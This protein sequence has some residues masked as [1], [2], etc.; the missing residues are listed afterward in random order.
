[1]NY[2]EKY[3]HWLE[4]DII[5]E[6]TKNELRNIKDDKEIEDRFYK[7]LEFG[8][9]GLRGII[10]AGTNRMNIYTVSKAT[11]GFANYL[12][13]AFENPSVAIAYDS[14]NMSKEF[15]KATALTLAANNIKVYLYEGL[16]P[17]PVLS[18]TVRHLNCTGGVV[19]TA[20][21]NPKE[22]NGY[23]V[24]DEFGGQVTDLKAKKIIDFVNN[25]NDFAEIKNITE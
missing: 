14:R 16:R 19:I 6:E 4:S 15:A 3:N 12:N 21:H 5:N 11:Q 2:S 23:K 20:S 7:D 24:Y 13:E 1:M 9:G 25:I 22:Y 18:F 17:T 10:G 8:T